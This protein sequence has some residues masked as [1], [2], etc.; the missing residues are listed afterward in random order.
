MNEF[1]ALLGHELRN[2]LAPIR[3]AVSIL[4]LKSTDDADVVRS[5]QI[6]DRQ[7][8][9]LTKLVDDLLEAGRVSSGK[10]RLS[11][12]TVNVADVIQLTVEAS[13]PLFDERQ[14]LLVVNGTD[15]PLFVKGDATR[16]VQALNNLLNNA[17]KFSP[18]GSTITL[19]TGPHGNSVVVRVIDRGRGISPEA[20][21]GVFDL[22]VQE[23][24][25]GAYPDEGGLGIGLTLVRAIAQLHGGH[26]EARSGGAG[27]GSTFSMWLPLAQAP[28]RA[29]SVPPA[30]DQHA[31]RPLDVL[32]V[33]DNKDSADSMTLLVEMLGHTARAAY[34]GPDALQSFGRRAPQV[35]LLDLSMPGMT[36]F[37]VIQRIRAA[38]ANNVIVAAMTGLGSDEDIARTRTAGFDAHLTKPVD[39]PEL[40]G[41]LARAALRAAEG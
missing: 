24:P 1:L 40:E 28:A 10:I 41:V 3:N 22:F 26:V 34:D 23:H 11:H 8:A 35:V 33:D 38:S 19:E 16:L 20:L 39:L 12:D 31:N 15:L 27:K 37:D 36:G 21:D 4:K 7:L 18:V 13:Q 30:P 17:S 2:P 32:V 25:P 5:R 9:H 6:V 29:A 14:Q